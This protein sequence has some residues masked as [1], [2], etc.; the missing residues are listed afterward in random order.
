MVKQIIG[1]LAFFCLSMGLYAADPN[2]VVATIANVG[3]NPASVAVTPD[4]RF[5]YVVNNNEPNIPGGDTVAVLN[6]TTNTIEKVIH[7]AS[8]KEPYRVAINK[9]GTIAYVANSDGAT[10]SIIDIATNTVTGT[11]NGF[12]GP[13]GFVI[14][15]NGVLAYVNNYGGPLGVG[16]GNGTTVNVVNLL[17]NTIVG[18]ITVGLAPAGLAITPDGAFVYVI[19][20]VDGNP[21]TGTISII[22]TSTQ[23]VVGRIS[24]FSGPFGI[25]ITPNG[26]FAYVT[27]FGSNDFAPV[28]RTVSVVDLSTNTIVA[29]IELGIQPAGIAITPDGCL[30]Y[31]TNYNTLYLGPGFTNLTAG[32]GIVNIIDLCTNRVIPPAITVGSSPNAVAISPN[33]LFAYV[34]NYISNSVSVIALSPKISARGC[35]IAN[36]FLTQ[37]NFVNRLT[38][39]LSGTSFPSQYCIYRN[40]QLTDLAG[41]VGGNSFVFF[42]YGRRPNVTYTYYIVGRNGVGT[43]LDPVRVVVPPHRVR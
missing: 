29:T 26:R 22:Q 39:T 38:W 4:N 5:A 23:S 9:A 37:T 31:V 17:T 6:L 19:N 8:F 14:A 25:A 24:G 2:T 27:N 35:Q 32:E 40:P 20:Y 16:S 36:R 21:G 28:G 7:D 13:S 15:P 34:T 30:A 3:L 12:D 41:V 42:D 11:I 10:V 18:T 43:P 1:Y 33:G